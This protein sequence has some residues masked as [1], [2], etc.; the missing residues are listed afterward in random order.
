LNAWSVWVI[1]WDVSCLLS[2]PR[3]FFDRFLEMGHEKFERGIRATTFV[4]KFFCTIALIIGMAGLVLHGFWAIMEK[5]SLMQIFKGPV[6]QRQV[7]TGDHSPVAMDHGVVDQSVHSTLS[8]HFQ[9]AVS[10]VQ[11]LV[12]QSEAPDRD[13]KYTH[14]LIDDLKREALAPRRDK[15]KIDSTLKDLS[16]VL[17]GAKPFAEAASN[18]I[19]ILKELIG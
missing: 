18:A 1:A 7:R 8:G 6:D 13:K 10:Q 11:N 2:P 16:S 3:A 12:D 19:E 4:Q 5:E 9:H 14:F 17:E 15:A